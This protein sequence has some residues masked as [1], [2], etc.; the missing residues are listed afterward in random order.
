MSNEII[1]EAFLRDLRQLLMRYRAEIWVDTSGYFDD[2]LRIHVA[3]GGD[4]MDD[5]S[6][7]PYFDAI[8]P[9]SIKGDTKL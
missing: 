2:E 5:E 4:L 9:R 3:G 1:K 6:D 7:L 8:L